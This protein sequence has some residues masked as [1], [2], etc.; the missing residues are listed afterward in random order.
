MAIETL[1]RHRESCII[2]VTSSGG[3]SFDS[4]YMK[5]ICERILSAEDGI[6]LCCFDDCATK[7]EPSC[8]I[9]NIKT[10]S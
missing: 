4:G 1:Q 10:R 7:F 2:L 3:G 5:Q 9:R 6:R 8:S